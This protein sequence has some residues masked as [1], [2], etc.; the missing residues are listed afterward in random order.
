MWA[1]HK[2]C[3]QL[4]GG[5]G[6]KIGQNCQRIVLK[7]ADVGEGGVKNP[8]KLSMLFMDGPILY[9]I[10]SVTNIDWPFVCIICHPP[11]FIDKTDR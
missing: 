1:V 2:R 11:L 9:N 3:R 4:G 10:S 6:S 5:E 8:E 7:T